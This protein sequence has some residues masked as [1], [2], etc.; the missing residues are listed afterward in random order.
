VLA[1]P[2]VEANIETQRGCTLRCSYCIYHKDMNK[3]AYGDAE[4]VVEEVA[5]CVAR[6]VRKVRFVDANF[7]SDLGHAKAVLR[8]LIARRFELKL[9]FELIP[10]FLDRELAAL[11][12][13]FNALSDWNEITLGLGVQSI[14]QDALRR[15]RRA[16]KMEK[17]EST[18]ALLKEFGIYAKIDLIIGLP[19]E[20]M[21]SIERT[22]NFMMDKLRGY[23]SHLL[24]CHVMRGL[25]GTELLALAKEYGMEFSSRYEAHEL[26]QSPALPRADMVK[27]LRRTA[28]VFRL[29][30]HTGWANR[31]YLFD[32]VSDDTGV[33]DAYFRAYDRLGVSHVTLLDLLAERLRAVLPPDSPFAQEDFPSAES[34]WWYYS[35]VEVRSEL[36]VKLLDEL[37]FQVLFWGRDASQ[38][39]TLVP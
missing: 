19:G 32:E 3:I 21:A 31:E 23:R 26:Y 35:K 27:C 6:G 39:M 7:S 22:L 28:L 13:E 29:V 30:N 9:M 20:T 36:L 8:G 15:I 12:A 38:E 1:R 11:M 18:F 2:G 33:H 25:P 14:N 17:F 24:C 5:Y 10:G 34:W 37:R 16:I 4:R